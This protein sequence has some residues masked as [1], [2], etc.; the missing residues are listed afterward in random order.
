[1]DVVILCG[2]RGKRLGKITDHIAKPLVTINNKPLLLYTLIQLDK[3]KF[4]R[5]FLC[6]GY[7]S[8]QF[9]RFLNEIK[10]K[11]IKIILSKG[12]WR[13]ETGKRIYHL[14]NKLSCKFMVL[15]GDNFVDFKKYNYLKNRKS[16]K[17]NFTFLIQNKLYSN[18]GEGNIKINKKKDSIHYSVKRR[19][20]YNYVELGYMILSKKCFKYFEGNKN[21]SF[22]MVLN[23]L[24]EAEKIKYVITR[25]K[26]VTITNHKK[27]KEA[28]KYLNNIQ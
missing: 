16:F 26:Y 4:K 27:L 10:F 21:E 2:G 5:V 7:K 8:Y 28:S 15:Y 3:E 17:G 13:W 23:K 12:H 11:N 24:S 1:M 18:D 25:D 9:E 19:E 14:K 6:T 20:D 22:T